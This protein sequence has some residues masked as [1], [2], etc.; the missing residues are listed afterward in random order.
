MN[1]YVHLEVPTGI[2]TRC[3][4]GLKMLMVAPPPMHLSTNHTHKQV[5]ICYTRLLPCGA[6]GV[7]SAPC[8]APLARVG[9]NSG[10]KQDGL[11]IVI[12]LTI[13]LHTPPL[14]A[15]QQVPYR[16]FFSF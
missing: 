11:F 6:C 16:Y 5:S 4:T 10:S 3:L 13:F 2:L 8:S 9:N 14:Y 15:V 12:V 1:I 7:C